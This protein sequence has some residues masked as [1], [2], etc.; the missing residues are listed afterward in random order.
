[1]GARAIVDAS[2]PHNIT[3][4]AY[5]G[6]LPLGTTYGWAASVTRDSGALER[7][8]WQVITADMLARF[9]TDCAV[10]RFSHWACGHIDK[11]AVRCF[12]D[13]GKETDAGQAVVEWHEKL[14]DYP[15]ACEDH[16]S[17]LEYDEWMNFLESE[18]TYLVG[19][20]EQRLGVE[21]EYDTKPELV[22]F[23]HNDYMHNNPASSYNLDEWDE[24]YMLD[25]V[26]NAYRAGVLR[27][28][29]VTHA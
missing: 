3:N 22:E 4:F 15:V 26:W 5:F 28:A 21:L 2:N 10:E 1:M 25:S 18:V 20:W 27:Q 7:S 29:G 8:N 14:A 11:L 23:L 9:P 6:G 19:I 13:D 16:W 24:N 17:A 12:D